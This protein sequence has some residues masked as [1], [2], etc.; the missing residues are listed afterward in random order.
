MSRRKYI[1]ATSVAVFCAYCSVSQ[2]A[3]MS[4]YGE[5]QPVNKYS[6][7][8]FWTPD[9]PYNLRFPSPIY[10]TGP[11]LNTETCNN[12][13]AALVNS[14]C[15]ANNNCSKLQVSDVR[16]KIMVQLSQLPGHNYATSCGG[17]IDNAVKEYKKN[18]GNSFSG[19]NVVQQPKTTK[20]LSLTGVVISQ[21]KTKSDGVAERTAELEQVQSM[22]TQTVDVAETDF[23]K[24]IADLSFVDRVANATAGYEPYKDLK[25]Y[26]IPKFETEQEYYSR[27]ES[28]LKH[29]I[30]YETYNGKPK[31]KSPTSYLTGRGAK[32]TWRPTREYSTFKGWCENEDLTLNPADCPANC[33]MEPSIDP[34]SKSDKSFYACWE[35]D[36]AHPMVRD[37]Y[38]ECPD[39]K[40]M[41]EKCECLPKNLTKLDGDKCVCND[42]T[43]DIDSGCKCPAGSHKTMDPAGIC[44]CL[45]PYT[46]NPDNPSVCKC[47]DPNGDPNNGCN[48]P[49]PEPC[50]DP[51]ADHKDPNASCACYPSDFMGSDCGCWGISTWNDTSKKCVCPITDTSNLA[52]PEWATVTGAC[53][54]P[55]TK[56]NFNQTT[57]RCEEDASTPS[58][59]G[60]TYAVMQCRTNSP[61]YDL[62]S[63]PATKTPW[64]SLKCS[65]TTWGSINN[66]F[67]PCLNIEEGV[68]EDSTIAKLRT[69]TG[70]INTVIE[71]EIDKKFCAGLYEWR[72]PGGGGTFPEY[73]FATDH[74][75]TLTFTN[76]EID[77]IRSAIRINQNNS[78]CDVSSGWWWKIYILKKI[79]TDQWQPIEDITLYYNG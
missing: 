70:F 50:P 62:T 25:S 24:T 59:D 71:P 18:H 28:V 61:V 78:K 21:P 53:T 63:I 52:I 23:P 6:S 36:A 76:L 31:S 4:K 48:V 8:P 39:K 57:K 40:H 73:L 9:S 44:K 10:A 13:V 74:N 22:T 12:T 26:H 34:M 68:T 75:N 67:T 20:P 37:H 77:K 2:S 69:I 27:M 5:I 54:C 3:V 49:P 14:Y 64:N 15:S 60:E 47:L 66:C 16:P 30:N 43:L 7:N 79:G 55:P 17:Y 35:C 46:D 19:I 42:T 41:N 33:P 58:D 45:A 65:P 72:W 29:N 1:F 11:D 32:I 51:N 38:C 56:P